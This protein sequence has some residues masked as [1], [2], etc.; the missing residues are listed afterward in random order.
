MCSILQFTRICRFNYPQ[1]FVCTAA[2][3]IGYFPSYILLVSHTCIHVLGIKHLKYSCIKA[4]V[5]ALRRKMY[6]LAQRT[7][8]LDSRIETSHYIK[9]YQ[10]T[11]SNG[12][13][14]GSFISALGLPTLSSAFPPQALLSLLYTLYYFPTPNGIR[15]SIYLS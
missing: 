3:G 2:Y 5:K 4:L 12:G 6:T 14:Q 13:K 1:K 11:N 10:Y 15:S 9:Q 7:Y 8:W